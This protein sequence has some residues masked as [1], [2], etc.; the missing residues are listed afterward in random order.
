MAHDAADPAAPIGQFLCESASLTAEQLAE[1]LAEQAS[2]ADQGATV[3]LGEICARRGWCSAGDV[4]AALQAQQDAVFRDTTLG[5]LLVARGDLSLAQLDE[6]LAAQAELRLPLGEILVA[7][8]ACTPEQVQAAIGLQALRRTAAVRN[9]TA[10]A[11]GVF[12]VTEILVNQELDAIRREEGACPCDEC[13]ANALALALDSLPARY[14]SDQH[15]LMRYAER[16]RAESIDLI[17]ER[18][19]LAVR[20][21]ADRPK[22]A[23]HGSTT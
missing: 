12:N 3:P 7:M 16:F 2:L 15:A 19:R 20:R 5:H 4:A 13:R 10:C 18:I 23:H 17:R 1:A 8:G 22:S 11:F 6:A 9:L 21:V 14:V